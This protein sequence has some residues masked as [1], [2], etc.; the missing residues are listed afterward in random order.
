MFNEIHIKILMNKEEKKE[1]MHSLV[2]HLWRKL[3]FLGLG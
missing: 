3:E 2:K 1:E